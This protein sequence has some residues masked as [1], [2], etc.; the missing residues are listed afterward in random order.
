MDILYL[1][2]IAGFLLFTCAFAT[3]CEK[4]GAAR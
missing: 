4:L 3:G 1:G 2:M